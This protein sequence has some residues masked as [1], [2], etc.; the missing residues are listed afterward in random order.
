MNDDFLR[1]ARRPP[2][3]AFERQL[4]ERLRQQDLSETSR[5]RPGWKLPAI[6]LLVAGSALATAT[7][8]TMSRVPSSSPSTQSAQTHTDGALNVAS[9]ARQA[10]APQTN[11]LV[12]GM[13]A[14][15]W[16]QAPSETPGQR[17][18]SSGAARDNSP[19]S[20]DQSSRGRAETG[21]YISST[22]PQ[23]S[24]TRPIR[25]VVS[26]DIVTLA[27]NTSAG[28]RQLPAASFEVDSAAVALPSLCA[29][30]PEKQPDVVVTSRRVR[31]DELKRCNR[32][33]N[34]EVLETT[35]GHIAIVVTRAKIGTPMQ[36]SP[37]TLRLAVLKKVPAPDD[38]SR[39]IDNP[40]THWNQIDPALEDRRIEVLGPSR[41]S[42]EFIVFAATL[43]EPACEDLSSA[44][45]QICLGLREDGAYAEA[46]FD[47]TFVRQRLWSDPNLVAI[48]D[49]RFYAANSGDLLGSL[50]EGAA[51]TRE[52]IVAGSYIGART[53]HAYVNR[54]R[55]RNIPR[56]S[57]F[58]NDYLRVY[59]YLQQKVMIPP[60]GNIDSWRPSGTPQ[61]TEVKLD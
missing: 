2:S 55:Y 17:E 39:L 20:T 11:P 54:L 1:R 13:D 48:V 31:K 5:R 59:G 19:S 46:R 33:R 49:Y 30:E 23:T 56:V 22:G 12:D 35:F 32:G 28:S 24:A 26:P 3:A 61:L 25:I 7:Y 40:Y 47:N 58:V 27:N 16:T 57:W 37:R 21:G 10:A 9:S 53:L 36:L 43:L 50:L 51:P 15:T 44:D 60:D 8:L 29:E 41:D 42:P 38:R 4:R 6:F 34:G 45:K 52:S 18:G 14:E